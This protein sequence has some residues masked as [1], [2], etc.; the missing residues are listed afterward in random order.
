VVD[1]LQIEQVLHS[2]IMRGEVDYQRKGSTRKLHTGNQGG[3]DRR[4]LRVIVT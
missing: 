4:T 2:Q 3:T 1:G